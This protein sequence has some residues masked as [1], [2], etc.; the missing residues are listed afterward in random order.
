MKQMKEQKQKLT[1][2][3]IKQIKDLQYC[4]EVFERMEA[5]K[6]TDSH[7]QEANKITSIVIND[8]HDYQIYSK[9][10]E[11]DCLTPEEN[12][13]IKDALLLYEKNGKV[14][15][16]DFELIDKMITESDLNKLENM[17]KNNN[18]KRR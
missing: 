11:L 2:K 10:L 3:D 5:N 7:R 16:D 12:T 15:E 13:I 17:F 6:A 4:M 18:N 1:K 9:L 8:D 14:A